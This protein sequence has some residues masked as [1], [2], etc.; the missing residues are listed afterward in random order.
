MTREMRRHRIAFAS[1][2]SP[3][4]AT[5]QN[6]WSVRDLLEFRELL[7]HPSVPLPVELPVGNRGTNVGPAYVDVVASVWRTGFY[8]GF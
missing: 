2:P 3:L 1:T 6:S 8:L 5:V 4:S 7:L